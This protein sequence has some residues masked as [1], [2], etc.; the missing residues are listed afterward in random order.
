MCQKREIDVD[1]NSSVMSKYFSSNSLSKIEWSARWAIRFD[2]IH[3]IILFFWFAY[4]LT[5]SMKPNNYR[6]IE[7]I[8]SVE[9][10]FICSIA[11]WMQFIWATLVATGFGFGKI[12]QSFSSLHR[13]IHGKCRWILLSSE[14]RQ[15][16][17]NWIQSHGINSNKSLFYYYGTLAEKLTS[18]P[19]T[20]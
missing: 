7:L 8:P 2:V 12:E 15:R 19:D 3:S 18:A 16:R 4:S 20:S 14:H 5:E 6:L 17:T 11:N 13:T 9:Q 10:Q 1:K